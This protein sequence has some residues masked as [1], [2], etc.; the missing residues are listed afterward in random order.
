M[1]GGSPT[2]AALILIGFTASIA[3]IALLRELLAAFGGNEMSI[4]LALAGWLL[5][6]AAGA[7]V[8]TLAGHRAPVTCLAWSPDGR[9]VASAG[10]DGTVLLIATHHQL[11]VI[12]EPGRTRTFQALFQAVQ[13]IASIRNRAAEDLGP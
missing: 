3:Q 5:W 2:R 10:R 9:L 4:G 7:K 11:H 1:A 12:G 13:I 6:T 8:A